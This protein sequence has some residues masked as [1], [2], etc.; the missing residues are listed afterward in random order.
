MR[1]EAEG[2]T[3]R[4]WKTASHPRP[5]GNRNGPEQHRLVR[6]GSLSWTDGN[7]Q[8]YGQRDFRLEVLVKD[9]EDA[10]WGLPAVALFF[11]SA[12]G[13]PVIFLRWAIPRWVEQ[14]LEGGSDL[15]RRG[16]EGRGAPSPAPHSRTGRTRLHAA[17]G[18]FLRRAGGLLR[19]RRR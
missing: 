1:A 9:G 17:F 15:E 18:R 3:F 4:R 7:H 6:Q 8:C 14:V 5:R 2:H 13:L 19:L 12:L 11:A 10:L 16:I